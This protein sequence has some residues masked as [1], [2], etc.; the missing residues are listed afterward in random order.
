[1]AKGN[2][3]SSTDSTMETFN[4]IKIFNDPIYGLVSFPFPILYDLIEHRYFQR[5]RRIS[6]TGLTY[7]VYPGAVHTRFHHALGALH[8]MT[9]AIDTIR[10]KGTVISDDEA[11]AVCIAILLH[12]IG[13]GPFSHA[14][15]HKILPFHHEKI[16][17][18]FLE[19][20]NDEFGGR[21]DLAIQ[22]FRGEYD[23]KFLHQ[24][25]SSQL[26]MDRMD[27]LSRDSFF[28]GVA[29]G[30]IGYDRIIT[31]LQVVDDQIVLEEKGIYSIEKFLIARNIMY[32][33]VYLHKTVLS[34]EKMLLHFWG[35]LWQDVNRDLVAQVSEPLL[36]I[37]DN[38]KM[39][40]NELPTSNLLDSFSYLDD[41]DVYA[42]LKKSYDNS[43]LVL[44]LLS[45]G[46]LDRK[47]HKIVLSE[48]RID[49]TLMA[50]QMKRLE[51]KYGLAEMD[52]KNLIF[53]GEETTKAY[54]SNVD[55]IKFLLRNGE[56]VDLQEISRLHVPRNQTV[57]YY[58]CAPRS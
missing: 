53:T 42:A 54:T 45:Q 31:M 40:D 38:V 57:K 18:A 27:Y 4:K 52:T 13:H 16:S 51:E 14:L 8:L 35:R 19:V 37:F 1:M 24:L 23:R 39:V 6:Q 32:W 10:S 56:V 58:L 22:I 20:L 29:E 43:D 3:L 49:P 34:A 36:S 30:I 28:T 44:R 15:E 21:L 50:A 11:E 33:Q 55:E 12:D 25:V 46:L 47:L 2:G 48:K 17:L 41:H 5:L 7:L 26:D 9:R